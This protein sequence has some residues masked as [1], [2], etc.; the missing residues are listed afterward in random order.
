MFLHEVSEQ[1]ILKS[2]LY[3][4]TSRSWQIDTAP[5]FYTFNLDFTRAKRR[6]L[7]IE[8]IEAQITRVDESDSDENEDSARRLNLAIIKVNI[9]TLFKSF[10]ACLWMKYLE[11]FVNC[12]LQ[13][14]KVSVKYTRTSR[15]L[16]MMTTF[17]CSEHFVVLKDAVAHYCLLASEE[18][19]QISL[20]LSNHLYIVDV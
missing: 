3:S 14:S 10:S 7:Q 12:R 6:K 8:E 9:S 5:R 17:A 11:R 20:D 13:R 19:I 4:K 18:V 16:E 15:L 1:I 2:V